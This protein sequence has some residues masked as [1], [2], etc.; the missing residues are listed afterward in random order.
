MNVEGKINSTPK[1]S[2]GLPV[3]NGGHHVDEVMACIESQNF[4]DFELIISDNASNDGTDAVFKGYAERDPRVRYFRQSKN[5]GAEENFRF[6]LE[7]SKGCYF[8]WWGVD[9]RRTKDFL[10]LNVSF[11]DAHPSFV[12]S[13][14]P[15]CLE[16]HEH[17]PDNYARFALTGSIEDRYQTFFRNSWRSHGIFYSLMRT[18][19]IRKCDNLFL[20]SGPFAADWAIDLFLVTKGGVNRTDFGLAIFGAQGISSVSDAWSAC[21]DGPLDNIMP[22]RHFSLYA[23]KLMRPLSWGVWCKVFA[24]LVLLNIRVSSNKLLGDIYRLYRRIIKNVK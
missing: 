1:V 14:C 17:A 22:L 15:D 21:R 8:M 24:S 5:L 3:F 12:A 7:Q 6:V 20:S 9:D 4:D 10:E 23:L 18:N 2:I 16:G 11:L 13:T 19:V